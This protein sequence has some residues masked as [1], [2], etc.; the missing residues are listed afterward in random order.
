[1]VVRRAGDVIA[2][3]VRV[4]VEERPADS[5]PYELPSSVPD[6]ETARRVQAIIHFASRRALDIEG[7]GEK[8]IEQLVQAGLVMTVA[9]LY[10]L[11]LEQLAALERM[12]DK[13]AANV[14]AAI[15]RS[16]TTTLPR[17]I[18]GLGIREVG[19]ATAAN[20]ATAFGRLERIR[21]AS[22]EE[23]EGVND[24]GPIVAASIAAWFDDA[25][26][27]QLLEQLTKAGLNWPEFEVAPPEALPL[28][29]LTLV[30]TGSLANLSRDEAKAR[31]EALGAKVAGSVSKKT[32][33]VVAGEE[34]GSKLDKALAL[35]IPVLDEAALET[36]LAEPARLTDYLAA[37][38][39]SDP[40]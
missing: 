37:P 32:S 18:H 20:L 5:L 40:S 30:L 27:L 31:L 3:V 1:M 11:T 39:A 10:V 23:L 7:L 12:G 24:I 2:E 16:K 17:L 22:Q 14:I 19:E 29:G 13:S 15:E 25:D 21:D 34:A 9:D 28:K 8:L 38:P 26:N 6:Q 36:L 35:G 4:I 33:L